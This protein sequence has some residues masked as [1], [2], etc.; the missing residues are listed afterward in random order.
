MLRSTTGATAPLE[1]AGTRVRKSMQAAKGTA[2]DVRKQV[3]ADKN[4]S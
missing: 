1:P 3:Q 4:A 2:Q